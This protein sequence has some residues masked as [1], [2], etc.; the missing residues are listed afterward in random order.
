MNRAITVLSPGIRSQV[1]VL[2]CALWPAVAFSQEAKEV[3][4]HSPAEIMKIMEDSDLMYEIGPDFIA[5]PADSPM[6]LS[7]QM[8][9]QKTGQGLSLVMFSISEQARSVFDRA[10]EAFRGGKFTEAIVHYRRLLE[11]QPDYLHAVTLI[12]DAYF[13]M[14]EFDSAKANLERSIELNFVDFYAHWFLADTYARMGDVE[15]A[16]R[17]ATIAHVLNVNH[18]NLQK[19]IRHHRKMAEHPWKEWAFTPEY[20]ISKEGKTVSI[21]TSLEWM[22]YAMV[23]AVWAYEPGYAASMLDRPRETLAIVWPEEKEA[24]VMLLPNK[25]KFQHISDII[26]AGYFQE[27][28]LYEITAR[29]HPSVLVVL[30][31]EQF[32]RVVEY[33]NMFH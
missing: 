30:P 17:E 3:R 22:G 16:S 5:A 4:L 15:S 2:L 6:V 28:V 24:I 29:R 7:N 12:G 26:D 9:L 25:E 27:F 14:Q 23:K 21:Q 8:Y 32:M 20:T 19:A 31:H 33:V 11:V 18:A 10:E 1:V 13:C